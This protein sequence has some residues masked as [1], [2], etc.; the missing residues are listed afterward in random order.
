MS[1]TELYLDPYKMIRIEWIVILTWT[2][3]QQ[4]I[5]EHLPGWFIVHGTLSIY[6]SCI[7]AHKFIWT[8]HSLGVVVSS[9]CGHFC[10]YD[11]DRLV[12]GTKHTRVLFISRNCTGCNLYLGLDKKVPR[13]RVL[14]YALRVFVNFI[15]IWLHGVTAM[16]IIVE[17]EKT[18]TILG[19]IQWQ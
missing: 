2:I 12:F 16:I 8:I 3:Q 7:K 17:L 5:T 6:S 11:K 10:T 13:H 14:L 4:N 15:I 9:M 1:E 19:D 18:I